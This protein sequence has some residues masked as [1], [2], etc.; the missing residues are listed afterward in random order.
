M[1]Y[2]ILVYR[3]IITGKLFINYN[4]QFIE[5][6]K[7]LH[8][9]SNHL[10][11]INDKLTHSSCPYI[12]IIGKFLLD[13]INNSISDVI[14]HYISIYEYY[15]NIEL[16]YSKIYNI[17]LNMSIYYKIFYVNK[18]LFN[19]LNSDILHNIYINLFNK[20]KINHMMHK[21]ILKQLKII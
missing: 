5:L 16:N 4:N 7:T 2:V 15:T 14:N 18:L 9:N 1:L 6:T 10:Y 13:N 8:I 19:K 12:K 21:I 17:A 3:N 11:L 20:Y